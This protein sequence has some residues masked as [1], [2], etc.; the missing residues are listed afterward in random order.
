MTANSSLPEKTDALIVGAG[1]TGLALAVS[2][3][4][5]G[6]DHVLVDRLTA[7]H[8]ASRAAVI[9]AHTLEALD[10][11]GVA[12]PLVDAGLKLSRFSLRDRDRTLMTLSFDDL[13]SPFS[14]LLMIPQNVTEEIL[15]RRLE[16]LGGRVRRSVSAEG[17]EQTRE[18]VRVTLDDNGERRV[19]QARY[20]I[21]ADGMRSAVRTAAGIAFEGGSDAHSFVLADVTMDWALGREEV[22]LFFSPA[23]LVVVAPLPDGQFRI[24]AAMK[25]APENPTAEDIAALMAASGPSDGATIRAVS[26]SSRFRI[27]HS[28]A[29][30]YRKGRML[31]M[32]DAAHVHSPAGG[33]GMNTGLV[34][35]TVLGEL[36]ADVLKGRRAE[37]DLDLYEKL[38]RPAAAKVMRLA[39]ALSDM[40]MTEGRLARAA[41]NA[42]LSAAGH[43]PFVRRKLAMNLSGLARREAAHPPQ[44]HR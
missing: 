22:M 35:A 30:S 19:V 34:D 18:G 37:A 44:P 21:G 14:H 29:K 3:G 42:R 2:L 25:D 32:G 13:P 4:Q 33:Q 43:L 38:R 24:V 28:L 36:L 23:G 1:P 26:W 31:V 6:V 8:S 9:H 39:G 16:A 27:H 40:A 41:R 11:L 5:A 17:F 10:G 7:G 12:A 20:V 15:A